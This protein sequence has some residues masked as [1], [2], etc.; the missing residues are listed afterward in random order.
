VIILWSYKCPG[1]LL[2]VPVSVLLSVSMPTFVSVLVLVSM[3]AF[4]SV[5]VYYFLFALCPHFV[6]VLVFIFMPAFIS[7]LVFFHSSTD[8][9]Y[10]YFMY[11]YFASIFLLQVSEID[12]MDC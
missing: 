1:N 9:G 3:P 8:S 11:L 6:S 7:V 5:L 2:D 12:M 4:I 10:A